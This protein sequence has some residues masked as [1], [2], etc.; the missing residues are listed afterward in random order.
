MIS[1]G[2]KSRRLLLRDLESVAYQFLWTSSGQLGSEHSLKSVSY[3][4]TLIKDT[5]FDILEKKDF[6]MGLVER[7]NDLAA[8]ELQINRA[9]CTFVI[10]GL[11]NRM[12]NG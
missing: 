3:V 9:A 2:E 5:F 6:H 7:E 10:R 8:S 11:E 1:A 4:T 12:A